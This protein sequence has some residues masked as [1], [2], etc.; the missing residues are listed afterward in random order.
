MVVHPSLKAYSLPEFLAL[1]RAKPEAINF[2]SSGAGSSIH[3]AFELF[4][5][6]EGEG[7]VERNRPVDRFRYTQ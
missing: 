1:A 4:P 7:S 5:V 2:G 3:L 6:P